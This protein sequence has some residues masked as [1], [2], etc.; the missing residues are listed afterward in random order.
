MQTQIY[1]MADTFT[2][3]QLYDRM[4][5]LIKVELFG[6]EFNITKLVNTFRTIGTYVNLAG[7]WAVAATGGITGA[8]QMLVQ[9]I[10]G[11]YYDWDDTRRALTFFVT[12][13]FWSGIRNIG[14]RNYK[15]K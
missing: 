1:K 2:D 14:N 11:R 4:N 9:T 5:S 6:K 8:Y 12:D 3:M 13:S 15:S 10:V 7:N